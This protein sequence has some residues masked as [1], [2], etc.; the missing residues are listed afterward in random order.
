MTKQPPVK[1]RGCKEQFT[2]K[3][4]YCAY[5]REKREFQWNQLRYGITSSP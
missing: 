3:G 1:C 2:G 4:K 5:C